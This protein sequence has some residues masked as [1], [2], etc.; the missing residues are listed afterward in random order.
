MALYQEN[1]V[2]SMNPDISD[3]SETVI[4]IMISELD[5]S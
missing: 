1:F 4:Q 2:A 3:D 5:K